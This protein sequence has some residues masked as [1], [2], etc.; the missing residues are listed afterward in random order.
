MNGSE[1]TYASRVV[2]AGASASEASEQLYIGN[3][4]N[5]DRTWDGFIDELKVYSGILT[6]DQIRSEMNFT[7]SLQLGTKSSESDGVTYGSSDGVEFCVPGATE[8]CGPPV[9]EWKFDDNTGTTSK[10]SSGNTFDA[11]F[12]NTPT[13][14]RGRTGGAILLNEGAAVRYGP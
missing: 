1:V 4:G 3:T 11:T 8:T 5:G 13:W 6:L 14:T 9:G 2:G 10:E 7:N 12:Y